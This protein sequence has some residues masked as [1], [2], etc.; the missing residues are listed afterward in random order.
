MQNFFQDA[1]GTPTKSEFS[2][3]V[4]AKENS[5]EDSKGNLPADDQDNGMVIKS[6]QESVDKGK[7][8]LVTFV[9]VF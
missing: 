1:S 7:N 4:E 6:R 8:K 3:K 9:V 2:V 5:C